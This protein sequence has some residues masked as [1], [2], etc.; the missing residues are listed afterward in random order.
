[1][2]VSN[3]NN[4]SFFNNGLSE[5]SFKGMQNISSSLPETPT[6][7]APASKSEIFSHLERLTH[8]PSIEEQTF[9]VSTNPQMYI[10]PSTLLP[11]TFYACQTQL[12]SICSQPNL[13]PPLAALGSILEKNETLK[14][15]LLTRYLSLMGA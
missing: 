6:N 13:P 3:I 8:N 10:N 12:Q 2:A 15:D 1:M 11:N 9:G 7:P 14:Q 4:P 5:V